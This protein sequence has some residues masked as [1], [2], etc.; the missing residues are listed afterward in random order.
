MLKVECSKVSLTLSLVSG[1]GLNIFFHLL[2]EESSSLMMG[3][4]G[5][6]L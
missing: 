1:V 2:Q 3:E 4:Q 5:S 6:D